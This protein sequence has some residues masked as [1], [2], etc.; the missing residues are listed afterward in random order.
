MN[1]ETHLPNCEPLHVI[2]DKDP[3]LGFLSF[4]QP[5]TL[6]SIS[7]WRETNRVVSARAVPDLRGTY[8]LFGTRI[9]SRL[10][11]R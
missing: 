6:L 8:F 3:Y 4:A 5:G 11:E 7:K 2:A 10:D 1:F 9:V